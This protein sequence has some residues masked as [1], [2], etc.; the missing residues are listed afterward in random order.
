MN[1]ISEKLNKI[2]QFATA[3][4]IIKYSEINLTKEVKDW[5]MKTIRFWWKKLKKT[6][7]N[8][9]LFYVHA[10][11][12]LFTMSILPKGIYKFDA[13]PIKIQMAFFTEIEKTTLKFLWIHS[14]VQ[15]SCSVVSNSL[16]PH[17][18]QHA[19]P[20]YPSPTPGVY[21]NSCLFSRWCHPTISSSV[22]PFSSR[23]QSFPASGAFQMSQ[24]FIS[25]AKVLEFQLQYQSFQWTPRTDFL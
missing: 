16:W 12:K 11:E 25:V 22:I 3:S 5:T 19:R 18:L 24:F 7:I 13:I 23:L 9:E 14:S 4:K 21:S 20:P 15:F 17:W 1:S 8:G 10:S 2:I 6:Q